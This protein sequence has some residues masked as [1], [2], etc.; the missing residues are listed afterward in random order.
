MTGAQINLLYI[1]DEISVKIKTGVEEE[2]L[3]ER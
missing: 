3:S 2:E 1:F